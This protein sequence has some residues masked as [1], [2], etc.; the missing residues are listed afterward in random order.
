[1]SLSYL[2]SPH[3][4]GCIIDTVVTYLVLFPPFLYVK[5]L[6]CIL[7]MTFSYILNKLPLNKKNRTDSKISH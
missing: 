2:I 1:M 6:R 7:S 4:L 5:V 3:H